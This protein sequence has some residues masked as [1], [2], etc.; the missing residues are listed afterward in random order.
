MFVGGF[1]INRTAFADRL[2]APL[3]IPDTKGQADAIV[4]MGAGVVGECTP[5]LNGLR[6]VILASHLWRAGRAPILIFT[7]GQ[8]PGACPISVA[9]SRFAQEIGVPQQAMLVETT[10][11]DTHENARDAQPILRRAGA[12]RVLVVTDRLHMR[13]AAG[14]FTRLGFQVERASVP[15]YEGHINN[16][17]MLAS[18]AREYVAL[19]YYRLRGWIGEAPHAVAT[20]GSADST[21]NVAAA[22]AG[23]QAN[24][25][26]S[27]MQGE[28]R[29]SDAAVVVLGAS[30]AGGWDM[31]RVGDI[32]I[33]NR[34]IAGQQSFEMLERFERDVVNA[35]PRAV[36]LWGFIN[37]IFRAPADPTAALDRVRQSYVAMIALA[38][39]HRIEPIVVTEVTIRPRDSWSETLTGWIGGLLGKQGYHEYINRHVLDTNRWLIDLARRE[40]LL[41]LDF[42]TTLGEQGGRRRREFTNDDGSHITPAGYAALTAYASPILA[43][44]FGVANTGL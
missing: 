19:A 1:A 7:G 3:L 14:T 4:V 13:R 37:D 39:K 28:L 34:G 2:I 38:R 42:Q 32:P 26:R 36:I 35:R 27:L 23:E 11:R 30:Y 22:A 25:S 5:N 40:R 6:R 9:M 33:I 41:V 21:A 16:V 18:G 31:K 29:G 8:M 17:D 24:R 44:H 20:A 43:S 10:S 12:T 15:V